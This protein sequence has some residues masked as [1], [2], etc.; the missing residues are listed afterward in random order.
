[1]FGGVLIYQR[2]QPTWAAAEGDGAAVATQLE[3]TLRRVLDEETTRFGELTSR[4]A[5]VQALANALGGKVDEITLQDLLAN[6]IWWSDFRA[7]GCAVLVGDTIRVAW[8]VPVQK[9]TLPALA[10]AV[11]GAATDHA[12]H[13]ALVPDP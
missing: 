1:A 2:Q 9:P 8:Q 12:P 4:A 11:R 6:E 3:N 13:A 10:R 5:R 7:F